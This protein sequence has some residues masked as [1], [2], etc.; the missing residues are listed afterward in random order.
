[1]R[2]EQER[3]VDALKRF[4]DL[5]EL[6]YQQGATIYLELANAE[7][8]LFNAELAY[9][10]AQSQLFQS[11]ANLY[12]AMGGGWVSAEALASNRVSPRTGGE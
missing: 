6:R 7:Q 8:S 3:D 4:R 10:A 5:A 1:V 9:V 2:D 11:Y 12:K